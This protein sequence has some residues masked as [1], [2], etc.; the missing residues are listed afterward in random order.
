[1]KILEIFSTP[2]PSFSD[3]KPGDRIRTRKSGLSGTAE[4]V[5][6]KHPTNSWTAD[7]VFFRT[8]DG[9]RMVT[10]L[11]NV[12]KEGINEA[13]NYRVV[14]KGSPTKL[15]L[16][17]HNGFGEVRLRGKEVF[18][19]Y[20]GNMGATVEGQVKPNVD[21]ML[22]Q[23]AFDALKKHAHFYKDKA[24]NVHDAP[25][26]SYILVVPFGFYNAWMMRKKVPVQ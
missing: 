26:Y 6:P 21:E 17:H 10:P 16:L 4:K 1:M 23:G 15:A 12:I 24:G 18:I 5:V 3:V 7:A 13:E 25:S 14:R 11:S 20:G 19:S 22:G 2:R 9:K 8:D